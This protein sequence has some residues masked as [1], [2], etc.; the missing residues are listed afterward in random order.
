MSI[1]HCPEASQVIIA[2]PI[3][4]PDQPDRCVDCYGP[5]SYKVSDPIEGR[6][7]YIK[8]K[9]QLCDDCAIAKG[10]AAA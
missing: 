5:T 7:N 9:G 6:R 10:S 8:G 2:K 4:F 3:G 1:S